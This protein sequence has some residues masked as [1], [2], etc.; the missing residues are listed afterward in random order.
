MKLAHAIPAAVPAVSS[1]G[2]PR[3][4]LLATMA[5]ALLLPACGG[6]GAT[7]A[8]GSGGSGS[9]SSGSGGA[10]VSAQH[11]KIYLNADNLARLKKAIADGEPEA[12]R[13]MTMVDGQ[14][15]GADYYAFSAADAALAYQLS[16]KA[17][18][19]EYAIT[20]TDAFV[21]GEEAHAAAGENA[22]VASDSYLYVGEL[23]GDVALTYD[24][25]FDR[26]TEPQKTRWI[27]YANQ[28]VWN[29]WH[30][31]EAKWGK[32]S[33]PWSGWSVDN[34]SNNY[35]YSFLQATVLLGLATSGETE[36]AKTWLTT[37]RDDKI[38]GQLIPTFNADLVGG[39]SREG[40]GYGVS[41]MRLFHLYSIWEA[42]TGEN[43]ST[44]TPHTKASLV[45]LMHATAP[46][47]DRLAP[48]GDHARESTAS[49]FDY[50]RDYVQELTS[51]FRGQPESSVGQWYL[52]HCSVP[53]MS[54]HFMFV[55]DFLYHDETIAEQPLS[56]LSPVYHASGTGH[57]FAR[58]SWDPSAT[59]LTFIA[60]PYTESHAHH[61]QGSFTVYKNEWLAYD[62]NIESHSG[63]HQ[64][65]EAHN[66]VRLADS[67]GTVE[68]KYDTT[69]KLLALRDTA[70]YA[71][72]AGDLTP[73]YGGDGRVKK[74]ER[75]IVF[76]KPDA[77]VVFDR[78]DTVTGVQKVWQLSTESAPALSAGGVVVQGKKSKLE[79]FPILPG[80]APVGLVDWPSADGD[81]L[82]GAR[83][84]ITD[85][86]DATLFLNVLSLDG[87]VV[88]RAPADTV[89]KKG[90][91]I[92]LADGRT[93]TVQL[94]VLA[95]GGA[96]EIR[97]AKDQ[98]VVQDALT[99]GVQSTPIFAP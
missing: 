37:F 81:M 49:L 69:A 35:Y 85:G 88:A 86:S 62:Q 80:G 53:E 27:A 64:E 73:A 59:W 71:Y 55:K 97:D 99:S 77:I 79:L 75:E 61:D 23:V 7:G 16:G 17:E 56:T 33:Y 70:A 94:G 14:L 39:G 43:L 76:I 60:G 82:G 66:L 34:P 28:A 78:V 38:G 92:T 31:D 46:T 41:M 22:E 42:S 15:G 3:A 65:E 24:W 32:D 8:G 93:A 91:K 19:A 51:F 47:L 9:G 67:G 29:V 5:C 68:M 30:H 2:L 74:V 83:V 96:I 58:S 52:S 72:V 1:P 26:L 40:T 36:V 21:T 45:Y 87:A 89:D 50:H 57:V 54:Q 84:D 98:I 20:M 13:F 10:H 6:D 11:P 12:T 63:L 95:A 90:V 18:Y 48:I 44:L 4:A 25:C